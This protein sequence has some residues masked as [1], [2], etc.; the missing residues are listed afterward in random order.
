M[1]TDLKV[2]LLGEF[3]ELRQQLQGIQVRMAELTA[4]LSGSDFPETE[5]LKHSA[6]PMPNASLHDEPPSRPLI[7]FQAPN[8][9]NS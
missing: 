9:N 3:M 4:I 1:T 8:S 2:Q 6:E 7:E 5:C